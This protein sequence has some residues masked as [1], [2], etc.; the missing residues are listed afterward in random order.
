MLEVNRRLLKDKRFP[1]L[2]VTLDTADPPLTTLLRKL[3]QEYAERMGETD[4]LEMWHKLRGAQMHSNIETLTETRALSDTLRRLDDTDAMM[5]AFTRQREAVN[6]AKPYDVPQQR[7]DARRDF[8]EP[9]GVI[10]AMVL[11]WGVGVICGLVW[12]FLQRGGR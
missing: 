12:S 9:M 5:E 4:A 10:V 2:N 7:Q 6:A 8:K 11:L 1:I 3:Y